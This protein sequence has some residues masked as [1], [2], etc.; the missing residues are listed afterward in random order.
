MTLKKLDGLS[1]NDNEMIFYIITFAT[2]TFGINETWSSFWSVS[3]S[4]PPGVEAGG[5]GD[6]GGKPEKSIFCDNFLKDYC[7]AVM[8]KVLKQIRHW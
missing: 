7:I 3:S 2:I 1:Y 4:G 5:G 6:G 8:I